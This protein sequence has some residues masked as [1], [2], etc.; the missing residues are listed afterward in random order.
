MKK[1]ALA[2]GLIT[3]LGCGGA[4]L[5]QVS[6]PVINSVTPNTVAAG[7]AAISISVFGDEFLPGAVVRFQG[8]D[9]VTQIIGTDE[10]FVQI[11]AA[12]LT[13]AG[14]FQISVKNPDNAVSGDFPF[15][16]TP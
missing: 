12:D 1:I 13:T 6:V 16:V 14:T 4:N 5:L 11:P 2:V 8:N 3:I 7:S 15:T 10:L 9:K